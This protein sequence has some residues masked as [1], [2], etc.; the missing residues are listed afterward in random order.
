MALAPVLEVIAGFGPGA[1]TGQLG[2]VSCSTTE[3]VDNNHALTA[4][5]RWPTAVPV[6]QRTKLRLTGADGVVRE[7]R[8]RRV[9]R[10]IGA[11]LVDVEAGPP[12]LDL[13]S[14]GVVRDLSG[15]VA[16]CTID[17][18]LTLAG[19]LTT[20]VLTNLAADGLTWLD[21]TLG[22]I[23]ATDTRQLRF[24]SATRLAIVN[25]LAEAFGLEWFLSQPTPG[26]L[27]R[28]NFVAKRGAGLTAYF[29]ANRELLTQTNDSND[30]QLVTHVTVFG[31]VPQGDTE[32]A[33]MGD[34]LWRVSAIASGWVTLVD[35]AGGDAPLPI[36]DVVNG[37][38]LAGPLTGTVAPTYRQIGDTRGSDSSVFLA[39]TT[40]LAVG[41][42]VAIRATTAGAPVDTLGDPT[43]VAAYDRAVLPVTVGGLRGEANFVDDG[44]FQQGV[45]RWGAV[46]P[47]TPAA[48]VEMARTETPAALTFA[49]NVPGGRSA[50][51]AGTTP[52]P[53][54]G[55]APGTRIL[56]GDQLTQAGSN[57]YPTGDA[58]PNASGQLALTLPSPGLPAGFADDAPITLVRQKRLAL[59]NDLQLPYFS[60]YFVLSNASALELQ[61]LT[62]FDNGVADVVVT[63]PASGT[64]PPNGFPVAPG[65]SGVRFFPYPGD[66]TKVFA[67]ADGVASSDSPKGIF[68]IVGVTVTSAARLTLTRGGGYNTG[69]MAANDFVTLPLSVVALGVAAF[70][71]TALTGRIVS[72]DGSTIVVDVLGIPSGFTLVG[73]SFNYLPNWQPA[74]PDPLFVNA[75]Y[76]WNLTH[77]AASTFTVVRRKESRTWRFSGAHAQNQTAV[78]LK[79]I[80]AL[81]TRH[82]QSGDAIY[83]EVP[84]YTV[85]AR[86][87]ALN[88]LAGTGTLDL[89]NSTVQSFPLSD[90][91][92]VFLLVSGTFEF[93]DGSSQWSTSEI[94]VRILSITG[95]SVTLA[96]PDD[97]TTGSVAT[98]PVT[99]SGDV[100]TSTKTYSVTGSASWGTDGAA[101]V[102][103]AA[104]G[105]PLAAGVTVW[106]NWQGSA[107]LSKMVVRTGF[108]AGVTTMALLADDE[109]ESDWNGTTDHVVSLY[110]VFGGTTPAP[111]NSYLTVPGNTFLATATVT[112]NGSGQASV[113]F[114]GSNANAVSDNAVLTLTR[115]ALL[116]AGDVTTGS[117][118]RLLYSPGN[119]SVP[120][121]ATPGPRS[122]YRWVDV[123]AGATRVV[124]A[125]ATLVMTAGTYPLG[126]LPAIAIVNAAGTV[127][128]HARFADGTVV[129]NNIVHGT[130]IAQ[131]T[132]TSSQAVAVAAYGGFTA[133]PS[134]WHGLIEAW[135]VVS[136]ATD[137]P[138]VDGSHANALWTSAMKY[139]Q[140]YA[141]EVRSIAVE[142]ANLQ[143][144][145][146]DV[147]AGGVP[148]LGSDIVLEDTGDRVRLMGVQL[149]HMDP[150][151]SQLTL[152]ALRPTAA[153]LL[154]VK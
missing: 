101:S 58:I 114:S 78:T 70:D 125:Y 64:F 67:V 59:T 23:E 79:P 138:F 85:T 89:A 88:V 7:Y 122:A 10:D 112:A 1:A 111:G 55:L 94:A 18:T 149:D 28:L 107:A 110:R 21:T 133:S 75:V 47:Q 50:G 127:L 72:V 152:D 74:L 87:T 92:T 61:F 103:I 31:D 108:A 51:V 83:A 45:A 90:V 4:R 26:G 39:N 151:R 105:Y 34:H 143:L 124:T 84:G 49:A 33:T 73:K 16:R 44:R 134:L 19:W 106:S 150:T 41:S 98:V 120:T 37:L 132:L 142:F 154:G 25:A 3:R 32:P 96:V 42:L 60:K 118:V 14:A 46:N 20:Y 148:A 53:V 22:T 35:P 147:A 63:D 141:R 52:L 126:Q 8:V 93:D 145:G 9:V 40:G 2:V 139:L 102:P 131:A 56:L 146:G 54:D 129:V 62:G 30:D 144:L 68:Q 57:H 76:A 128:G 116:R 6:T 65:A 119:A 113:P 130:L 71:G 13:A 5:L 24:Q 86:F 140:T 135:G 95:S 97:L 136:P 100:A 12:W 77:A 15:S 38:Y 29:S 121:S 36:D 153:R 66:T 27:Y 109:Y 99:V 137:V 43:A 91:Q 17:T 123:P 82:W 48:F 117:I 69:T 104:A 81:A 115:P 80:A 11:R